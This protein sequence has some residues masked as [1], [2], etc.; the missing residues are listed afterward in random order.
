MPVGLFV[1]EI[2]WLVNSLFWAEW[3]KSTCCHVQRLLV[4]V[5]DFPYNLEAGVEHHNIWCSKPL[6]AAQ[7]EEVGVTAR[8][9]LYTRM[10]FSTAWFANL[11]A[12]G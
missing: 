3:L 10:C 5:Q 4:T 8:V 9:A 2:E 12:L 1:L 7:I 11:S 6:S